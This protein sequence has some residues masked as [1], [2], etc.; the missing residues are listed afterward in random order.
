MAHTQTILRQQT[1]STTCM[2]QRRANTVS[3]AAQP[4]SAQQH[5]PAAA[6]AAV[7]VYVPLCVSIFDAD[8]THSIHTVIWST[9]SHDV[10]CIITKF[11]G[12]RVA[13]SFSLTK[14]ALGSGILN[15]V[16]VLAS[17][18]YS[19]ADNFTRWCLRRGNSRCDS[20]LAI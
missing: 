10:V 3:K 11:P 2:A 9:R 12:V 14:N 18:G 20:H 15:Q 5:R 1:L 4:P 6:T 17:I 19:T 13:F 7:H 8:G 16:L